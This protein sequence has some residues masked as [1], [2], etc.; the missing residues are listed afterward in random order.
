MRAIAYLLTPFLPETA[1]EMGH[2]LNLSEEA[3]AKRAPWGGCFPPGHR[4]KP[5]KALFPRIDL[6][7]DKIDATAS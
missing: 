3:V 2:L 7:A 1:K 5:P 6:A 4:V